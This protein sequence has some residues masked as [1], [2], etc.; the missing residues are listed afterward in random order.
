MRWLF[1][2]MA[3]GCVCQAAFPAEPLTVAASIAPYAGLAR[4][5]GGPD[6]NIRVLIPPGADPHTFEPAPKQ[7]AELARAD[8]LFIAG[9][10]PFERALAA[11][12]RKAYPNLK[13]VALAGEAGPAAETQDAHD[14]HDHPGDPHVWLS[15]VLLP[16]QIRR[17]ADTLSELNPA[18]KEL[19]ERNRDTLLERLEAVH[20]RLTSIL[21]PYRG[22]RFYVFHPAFGHFGKAYGLEQVA[23]ETGGKRPTPKQLRNLIAKAKA[24]NVA[25]IFVQPQFDRHSAQT[26]A[27]ALGGAVV[28]MDPLAE[29]VLEN[30]DDMAEKL[31]KALAP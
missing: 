6:V 27:A 3:G 5:I 25:I 24:D 26:V 22:R 16:A 4:Q 11:K 13:V 21:A 30:F 19:V 29:D 8:V 14:G 18:S 20:K 15:P 7:L 23:V 9:T 28:T 31:A 10:I 1:A 17:I 12:V 2:I